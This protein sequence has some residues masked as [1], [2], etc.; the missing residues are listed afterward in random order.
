MKKQMKN[1]FM[2]VVGFGVLSGSMASAAVPRASGLSL[3]LG[4]K[5]AH[6]MNG[7]M[8][9]CGRPARLKAGDASQSLA[10]RSSGSALRAK[11]Q[12]AH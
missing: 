10:S 6:Q 12:S 9:A 5:A 11:A 7:R 8:L 1:L 2:I 4:E 3:A